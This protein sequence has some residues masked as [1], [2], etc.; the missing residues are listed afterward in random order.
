MRDQSE[1]DRHDRQAG[2]Q[3]LV[4]SVP[5]EILLIVG[6]FLVP[7]PTMIVAASFG[8]VVNVLC[9]VHPVAAIRLASGRFAEL[10]P[11]PKPT[12]RAGDEGRLDDPPPARVG[13]ESVRKVVA[14]VQEGTPLEVALLERDLSKRRRRWIGVGLMIAGTCG[15]FAGLALPD[16]HSRVAVRV[17]GG[18]VFVGL[19]VWYRTL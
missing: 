1:L 14:A 16:E 9:I 15:C 2:R 6:A 11:A 8:A 10:F 17:A 7:A 12:T 18:A 4:I 13:L 5:I 3:L 19:V